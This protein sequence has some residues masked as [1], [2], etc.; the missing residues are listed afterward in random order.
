MLYLLGGANAILEN[1]FLHRELQWIVCLFHGEEKVFETLFKSLD[2]PT[3]SPTYNGPIGKLI[4]DGL[5]LKP[6]VDY[7]PVKTHEGYS[8]PAHLVMS[9]NNDTK[10]LF[11]LFL[12]IQNASKDFSEGLAK[13][14]LAKCHQVCAKILISYVTVR[15]L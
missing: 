4:R 8:V 2:G 7:V 10:L 1:E 15:D 11:D 14:K 12:A 9:F 5:D 6:I 13:R 3:N